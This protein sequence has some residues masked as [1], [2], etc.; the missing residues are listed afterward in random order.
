MRSLLDHP[1]EAEARG[2]SGRAA[3]VGGYN[4][5][6]EAGKLLDLYQHLEAS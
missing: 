3:I 6:A 2:R 1:D 5:E 4:W